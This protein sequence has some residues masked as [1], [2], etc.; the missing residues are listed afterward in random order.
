[1]INIQT[2]INYRIAILRVAA[3]LKLITKDCILGILGKG[4]AVLYSPVPA[5]E[6]H[7][8]QLNNEKLSVDGNFMEKEARN[9]RLINMEKN[10][11]N[12][13]MKCEYGYENIKRKKY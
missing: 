10:A 2:T 7:K 6:I 3:I 5:T 9:E 11:R 4:V 1:M 13:K 8:I 12:G